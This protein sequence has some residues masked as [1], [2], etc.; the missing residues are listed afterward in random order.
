MT[1]KT[2]E[3]RHQWRVDT[4][5]AEVTPDDIADATI[6]GTGHTNHIFQNDFRQEA[7]ATKYL[8][9]GADWYDFWTERRYQGGQEVELQTPLHQAPMMV[10]S[11]SI[12][13]L[14]PVMQYA[15][16]HQWDALDIVVFPGRNGQFTLYE[17]E[18]DS[19]RYE[20]G[21]YSTI[22]FTWNDKKGELTIARRQG[23]FPGM[24]QSRTFR[25][26]L[27]GTQDVKTVTYTGNATKV[28]L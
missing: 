22:A 14:A 20:Q 2:D 4:L 23:Q 17:D 10:R 7:K 24:L 21:L 11:G 1:I 18:G 9:K 12:L 3:Q 25:L 6:E 15:S 26:R 8:P 5:E 28:K 27:A 13:P 19:Y 16:E